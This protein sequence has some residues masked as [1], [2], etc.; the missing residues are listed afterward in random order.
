M[1]AK[2]IV[3]GLFALLIAI[4][5]LAASVAERSPFAQG[6]W[7][8]PNRSGNGFEIF[9]AAGEVAVLW[10]TYTDA[11]RPIW[12][13]AQGRLDRL[14]TEAWPLLEHRWTAGR[15][16]N[17]VIVGSLRLDVRNPESADVVWNIA[18]RQGTW[19]IRP[20]VV[21]GVIN[22]IDHSGVWFDPGNS[23]WG[24]S[25]TEQGD[26][27][28]GVLYTYDAAGAPTW[29]AAFERGSV[30]SVEFHSYAGACPACN[31]RP[32]TPSSVG[33]LSL[34]R[35]SETELVV[36]SNLNVSMAAGVNV[37][38]A[39][40]VQLG[41]PASIRPADRQL[42]SFADDAAL[43][44]YLA[45]GM[46]NVP[47]PGGSFSSPPPAVV[48]SPTNLQEAGVDEA[49]LVK[50]SGHHLYTYAHDSNGVRKPVVR[51]A[52]VG[53][54]GASLVVS[55]SV[56][57]SSGAATPMDSAGLFLHG[58]KLVSITGTRA[59]GYFGSPWT[60]A[61]S[62]MNGVT[63]IEV[64]ST[65]NPA[66]P[67]TRWRAEIEGHV[68]ASRRI[69]ERVYVVSR[70][71]P[72]LPGFAYGATYPP[73]VATNQQMLA[74]TPLSDLLPKVRIDSGAAT[75]AVAATAVHAPP[76][77]SRPLMADLI[78]ITAVDLTGPRIAQTLAILGSAD[79]VY[80]SSTDLFVASSRYVGRDAYGLLLPIEPAVYLT[81]IHQIRLG[82][83]AM[84]IVGSASIEGML[85]YDADKSAFR[86]SEHQG[87]L[88]VVTS[89][90]AMWGG[91]SRNRLTILEPS[92]LAP[93]L[94]KTVSYLPNARRPQ[95]LGKPHEV[96]YGVRFSGDRLYAVTFKKTDPLYVVDLA[97][98][99]DPRIAGALEIPGFSDYLHPLP[100]G[101]LLGFGKDARPADVI[102][103]GQF[104]WFQGLHLTLFDVANPAQPREIQR[105]VMGKRGSESALLRHHHAFSELL[106]S[107]GSRSIAIP[108]RIHDG[109]TPPYASDFDPYPWQHS[110]LLRFELR[111]T[112]AADARIVQLPSLI[113]HRPPAPH[114]GDAASDDARSVLFGKGTVYVGK[115]QFWRQD[116][117]G[118][119]FGPL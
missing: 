101:L 95:T 66:V 47:G 85:G 50:S 62:W 7:W 1:R 33:R 14:G 18:G 36:H 118:N 15:I 69:G 112:S 34:D 84:R 6:L 31:H 22:E 49:D 59:S 48:F 28:G 8:D 67:T 16:G 70:F 63:H 106:Q 76:Q 104:A 100:N 74:A 20:L 35:R 10:F 99:G 58:D 23:G 98:I 3:L 46:L 54:D 83:D 75:A 86:L 103:D 80:A 113:T 111:G 26:F 88:R 81:D 72:Y 114:A 107:D 97:D 60:Q 64:L 5:G 96:L 51:I 79:T 53:N 115:G 119:T 52:Q 56:F 116:S 39:R 90:T 91:E 109:P 65:L 71:V 68:V 2:R 117:L 43:H 13:T 73:A 77:G 44:G 11:G 41:R 12:Y 38:G 55:G 45:L 57:L 21:S 37:G 9:T 110:G 27:F 89:S 94:L 93:G 108:A 105:V 40:I 30:G 102:G 42:A 29:I 24:F 92:T 25:L 82:N 61:A 32:S 17:P 87:R 4:P 78:V 19:A